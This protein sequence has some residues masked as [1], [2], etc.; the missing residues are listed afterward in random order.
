M[1]NP[2]ECLY[3]TIGLAA[4]CDTENQCSRYLNDLPGIESGS[5]EDLT[6][7]ARSTYV[8]ILNKV[9]R[10]TIRGFYADVVDAFSGKFVPDYLVS[11]VL[12]GEWEQP[13]STLSLAAELQGT[14]IINT[15]SR[16]LESHIQS[17][18][19]Y[20]ANAPVSDFV[21]VYDLD[22]G[23]LLDSFPLVAASNG[24][25]TVEINTRYTASRLFVCYDANVVQ[26]RETTY[27]NAAYYDHICKPCG[28]T[29]TY[30]TPGFIAAGE[31]VIHYN[32]STRSNPGIILKYS[33]GCGL[34]TFICEQQERLGD[35]LLYKMGIEFF[36][37]VIASPRVNVTTLI[38]KEKLDSL[39]G[40]CQANY[41]KSL[42]GFASGT[43]IN[44]PLCMVCKQKVQKAIVKL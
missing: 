17:A 28:C 40:Y 38:E 41:E 15:R 26:S 36:I 14:A 21:Y 27:Y 44:D 11:N 10:R 35:A 39:M 1:S 5:F 7:E 22:R 30:G 25:V 31:E 18:E 16:Y 12:T 4:I 24:F 20:V 29:F 32:F 3:D 33:V 19:I 34:E 43:T 6:S 2:C 8:E 13:F 23:T 42:K 37:E 9:K